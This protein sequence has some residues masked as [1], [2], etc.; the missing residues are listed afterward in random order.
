MEN[1]LIF[2]AMKSR[3]V[4]FH[5]VKYCNDSYRSGHDLEFYRN[6][7]DMHR[8]TKN[9][10]KMLG[11]DE[12]FSLIHA[13]LKEW[14][15]DMRAADL[16][17]KE[18]IKAS[19]L[20]SK[21]LLIELYKYRLHNIISLRDETGEKV[22]R[23]LNLVFK[24][25]E[26]MRSK[27]QIVG[28][29]KTLHFLLPDLVLP[30]DGKYTMSCF[31]GYNKSSDN[32]EAESRTFKDIFIKSHKIAEMLRLGDSDVDGD[33]WNTSV[34][35]LIDNAIIGFSR[36]FE[37]YINEYKQDGTGNFIDSLSEFE[38]FSVMERNQLSIYLK[39]RADSILNSEREETR[40]KIL[41]E[42]AKKAGITVTEEE[43]ASYLEKKNKL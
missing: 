14:N 4:F 24:G 22:I 9:I 20:K 36:E 23:L 26:V 15:M 7:I 12:L 33:K 35:K 1:N 39:K 32:R 28:G 41:L 10:D 3:E 6:I 11:N 21:L 8:Q 13:T 29:S 17:T 38:S 5:F 19:I 30:M 34:P 27:R 2:L 16:Y 25:L 18:N 40:K 43:I 37:N 31:Y 42:K